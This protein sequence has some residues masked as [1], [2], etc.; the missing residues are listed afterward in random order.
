MEELGKEDFIKWM[1]LCS[2]KGLGSSKISKLFGLFE[3]I[4]KIY[5][6]SESDLLSTR[7]FKDEMVQDFKRLKENNSSDFEYVFEKC[8]KNNIKIIHLFSENYPKRLRFMPDAPL[9]LFALGNLNLIRTQNVAVVGSRDS[10]EQAKKWAFDNAQDIVK[11]GITVVS[12]GAK[13]IDYEAHRGALSING[14]TICVVGTGLLALYPQE[15]K[16]LFEQIKQNGLLLSEQFP[17]SKVEK[18]SL[19]RRNRIISGISESIIIVTSSFQGGTLTQLKI[20]YNQHIP[21]F[22]PALSLNLLPNEGIK[23]GLKSYNAKEI[24]DILPVI[25]QIEKT[26]IFSYT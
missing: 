26:N 20:A 16:E 19:V 11:K 18:L 17:D 12:G 14:N 13:G 10:S 3:D 8:K 22:C 5:S 1:T 25:K 7:I 15:H 2:I 6:A 4:E 24:N 23:E 9:N 21:I